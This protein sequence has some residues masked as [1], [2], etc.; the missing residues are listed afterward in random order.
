MEIGQQYSDWVAA[1]H[2]AAARSNAKD[3]AA[4]TSAMIKRPAHCIWNFQE[5]TNRA[6]IERLLR[7][8]DAV[9]VF[10]DWLSGSPG[11]SE[12]ASLPRF[13]SGAAALDDEVKER[14]AVLLRQEAQEPLPRA[15]YDAVDDSIRAVSQSLLEVMTPSFA[16]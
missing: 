16:P 1:L 3:F 11:P 4:V 15:G 10:K 12:I 7:D 14:C 13:L 5:V 8:P 9:G 6:V 2:L